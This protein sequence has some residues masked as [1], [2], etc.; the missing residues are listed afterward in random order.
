MH[1]LLLTT[2]LRLTLLVLLF[3][4]WPLLGQIS[5]LASIL[6]GNHSYE[7]YY[8]IESPHQ[9]PLHLL[10][11]T[12]VD[13][14]PHSEPPPPPYKRSFHFKG[15]IKDPTR[16]TCFNTRHLVLYR[17]ALSEIT[18]KVGKKGNRTCQIQS[19]SWYDPYSDEYF[20]SASD[21]QIDHLVPLKNT[22]LAGAWSW[23]AEKRCHYTNFLADPEHLIAVQSFANL[24]KGERGPD[25]YLPI[26]S[27]YQCQYLA[28]W[29]R[30]KATWRLKIAVKEGDAIREFLDGEECEETLFQ[31]SEFEYRRLKEQTESPP[32]ACT[33]KN[34]RLLPPQA[35]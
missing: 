9:G 15:W 14:E 30:I 35:S 32:E 18:Y 33:T 23:S 3:C 27:R 2:R 28:A 29:L 31:L 7:S 4:P 19:S 25:R 21:L 11:W 34:Q 10:R 6:R 12:R 24:S 22:Y 8:V 26:N 13:Q 1:G 16:Q 5:N 17:Q 20:F